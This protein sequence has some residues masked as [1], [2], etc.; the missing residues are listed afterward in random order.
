MNERVRKRVTAGDVAKAAG[1]SQAT[2]SRA[3][4]PDSKLSQETRETVLDIAEK[5]NYRPNP[6][7]RLFAKESGRVVAVIVRHLE[8]SV[9]AL[10]ISKLLADLQE[11]GYLALLFQ[12]STRES[13][14][15]LV[16]KV[17]EYKPAVIIVS[18]YTPEVRVT[19]ICN[20]AEKPLIILNQGYQVGT[21]ANYVTSD[22]AAGAKSAAYKLLNSGVK[23]I[24]LV[25]GMATTGANEARVKGFLQGL[26]ECGATLWAD[27][28][29]DHSYHGGY[30]AALRMMASPEAPDGIFCS[31][32]RMAMG[33]LDA[34]RYEFK[35][36][37]PD[38]VCIIGYDNID[39]TSWPSYNLTTV[40]QNIDSVLELVT[41]AVADLIDNPKQRIAKTVE[42][43][44][45]ERGTTR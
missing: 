18:G 33:F 11:Q 13:L 7:G 2:V 35:L 3:F 32:D 31:N 34:V 8:S 4:D 5:M 29:G 1:V 23:R 22:H 15:E 27:D 40:G 14:A 41:Q 38:D 24:G 20:R 10:M 28:S 30:E 39:E 45:I 43:S 26:E 44:L 17:L 21:L 9:R 6:V 19:T 12:S 37:V 42:V 25:S 16:P 36:K